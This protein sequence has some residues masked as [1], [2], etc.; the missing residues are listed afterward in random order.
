MYLDR[1]VIGINKNITLQLCFY[2]T[3]IMFDRG[4]LG[5]HFEGTDCID[6]L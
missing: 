6:L 2:P 3:E 1:A 5:L 4:H